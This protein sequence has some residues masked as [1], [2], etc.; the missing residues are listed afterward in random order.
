[1]TRNK[2]LAL[3]AA[4]LL[5][6]SLVSHANQ[7]IEAEASAKPT[8]PAT[9]V[10]MFD[11][12][13]WMTAFTAP[14]QPAISTELKFNAATPSGWMQWIDPKTHMPTHM[15]F[16]NPT[17]Y[18]QFMQPQFYMEFMK[19]ENMMAWMNPASYQVMMD[20]QTMNH[21]MNPASYMHMMDP[22]MY[23]ETMN[24][25]N[26]MTYLNP[27]TYAGWMGAQTCDPENPDQTPTW[28]GIGC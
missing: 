2:L 13:Y 17:S 28:F 24:P 7:A 6:V 25:A 12:N 3:A 4:A 22:A 27:A 15:T 23:Q 9:N 19:P 16:M 10:N 8:A 20:P 21:W 1:M 18:A 5:S 14:G 26:Y 11:P